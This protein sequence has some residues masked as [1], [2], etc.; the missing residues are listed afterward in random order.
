MIFA[1][2]TRFLPSPAGWY[3][4]FSAVVFPC[5]VQN[6]F[7]GLTGQQTVFSLI[8][9]EKLRGKQIRYTRQEAHRGGLCHSASHGRF[10]LI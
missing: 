4:P 10:C 6:V 9:A 1:G 7:R 8:F 5:S 3:I 2:H